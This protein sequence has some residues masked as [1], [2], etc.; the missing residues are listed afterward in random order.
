MV[1]FEVLLGMGMVTG[2]LPFVMPLTR[3]VAPGGLELNAISWS[4]LL[5]IVAQPPP[6]PPP[7]ENSNEQNV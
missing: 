4:D 6:P 2:V 3:T 7:R 1:G 5:N